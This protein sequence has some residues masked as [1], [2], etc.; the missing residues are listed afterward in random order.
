[1]LKASQFAAFALLGAIALRFPGQ[2]LNWDAKAMRFTN[3]KEANA[4]I[5]P[6]Y[7]KGWKL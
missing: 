7:R 2:T 3:N 6:P 4:Y 1:M 5:N